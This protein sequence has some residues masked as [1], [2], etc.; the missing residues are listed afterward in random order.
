M[1]DLFSDAGARR[2]SPKDAPPTT[3]F[4][5]FDRSALASLERP[6]AGPEPPPT[7]SSSRAGQ[8]LLSLQRRKNEASARV[9]QKTAQEA[10]ELLS[11]LAPQKPTHQNAEKKNDRDARLR[12]NKDQAVK[13]KKC[14]KDVGFFL[15]DSTFAA[16]FK[17]RSEAVQFSP[18]QYEAQ[19]LALGDEEFY[20]GADSLNVHQTKPDDALVEEM[21][22]ELQQQQKRREKYH[23]RRPYKGERDITYINEENKRFNQQ[24]EKHYGKFTSEIKDSL[25][26][27]TAL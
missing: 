3:D 18:S 20:A 24:L 25:E 26:R 19:R 10:E 27:G 16:S 1:E 11:P 21:V 13:K 14:K 15:D 22:Q 17:K 12:E 5:D 6:S 23:R 2:D 4:I 8:L 9:K 7:A